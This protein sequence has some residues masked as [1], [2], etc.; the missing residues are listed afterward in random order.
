MIYTFGFT[1]G[2]WCDLPEVSITEPEVYT[3]LL[4]TIQF[5]SHSQ[6]ITPSP[7]P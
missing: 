2:S 1:A 3:H 4:D 5:G 6:T 7:S